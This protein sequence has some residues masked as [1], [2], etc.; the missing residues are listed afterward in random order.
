MDTQAAEKEYKPIRILC[1]S[2]IHHGRYGQKNVQLLKQWHSE[3]NKDLKYDYVFVSGDICVLP[4]DKPVSD[5][6]EDSMA[7][8]EI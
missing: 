7:E 1:L 4:N 5:P 8:G 3:R 2:D 6:V